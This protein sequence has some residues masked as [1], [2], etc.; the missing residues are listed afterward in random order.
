MRRFVITAA[1]CLSAALVLPTGAA[2]ATPP[3]P[4]EDELGPSAPFEHSFMQ[5]TIPGQEL[6]RHAFDIAAGE[7]NP[8]GGSITYTGTGVYKST[9]GGRSWTNLGL[10]DSGA[11]G[12]IIVDPRDPRRIFVAATGS[13]FNQGGERGVYRST[14]GG[15]SW[16][17]V[18][19]GITDTT[20]ASEVMFDP[21]NSNRMFA[22]LWDH[23]RQPNKRSYSGVGSR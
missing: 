23:R 2:S 6:P 1:V 3:D 4:G 17:R 19:N 9:N 13:L 14:D 11:I 16:T 15:R 20:G 10:R 5:K 18:L 21:T 12:K 7:P 8:G 22:V